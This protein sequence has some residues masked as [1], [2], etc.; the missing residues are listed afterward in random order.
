MKAV[1]YLFKVYSGM[2]RIQEAG[3]VYHKTVTKRL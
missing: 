2:Q 3:I 1:Y